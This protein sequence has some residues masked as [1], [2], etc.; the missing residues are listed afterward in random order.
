M[1][2]T[3]SLFVRVYG[4]LEFGFASLKIMLV[5]G[6]NIMALVITCGGG[7]NHQ[8]IGFRYW[9]DPGPFVQYLGFG[10]ALGQFLGT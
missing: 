8:A 4:E 1:V 10:G 9:D 6:V 2:I 3:S 5:I 7:P